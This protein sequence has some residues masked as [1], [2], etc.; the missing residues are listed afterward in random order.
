MSSWVVFRVMVAEWLGWILVAALMLECVDSQTSIKRLKDCGK[1]DRCKRREPKFMESPQNRITNEVPSAQCF[2]DDK[3]VEFGDCCLDIASHPNTQ[4]RKDMDCVSLSHNES[5]YAITDCQSENRKLVQLCKKEVQ[6]LDYH[7]TLDIPVYSPVTKTYFANVYCSLCDRSATIIEPVHIKIFCSDRTITT[8]EVLNKGKYNTGNLF[9]EIGEDRCFLIVEKNTT[10][11]RPCVDSKSTC[12]LKDGPL[13]EKCKAYSQIVTVGN[14]RFKN[15]HCAICNGHNTSSVDCWHGFDQRGFPSLTMLFDF[16]WNLDTCEFPK[17]VWDGLKRQCINLSI[18]YKSLLINKTSDQESPTD[19]T[20]IAEGYLTVICL[21]TSIFC[22]F[23]HISIS[24][25]LSNSNTLPAKILNSL[26]ISLIIAQIFF[27]CG[28]DPLIDVSESICKT[29]AILI[30][31]F[32]L[33]S[34][35]WMNVMSID[36]WRTFSNDPLKGQPRSHRKYAIYAWGS[37]GLLTAI[38][39]IFD[40][41]EWIPMK[42][43][44]LYAS[45]ENVCWFA[46]RLGLAIFFYLPISVLLFFNAIMFGTTVL[47]FQKHHKTS[48]LI[49]ASGRKEYNRLWLYIKLFVIMGLTWACGMIAALAKE[50]IF[51][52]PF[53][54]FNGL[55]GTFLFIMFD[56]KSGV[57]THVFKKMGIKQNEAPSTEQRKNRDDKTQTSKLSLSSETKLNNL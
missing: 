41:T 33:S 43:R 8:N 38:S 31:F 3:C 15:P 42:F 18:Q 45:A 39:L 52:Y 57:I 21:S 4:L 50:P 23:I 28:I 54:V 22:L 32:F 40:I 37:T 2:C 51:R 20:L 49:K 53:I 14:Q 24:F 47:G 26:S 56:L 36:L 30:H 27:L 12:S 55:Q 7:Y 5:V 17:T 46:N 16:N 1:R 10:H 35:F 19:L 29:V 44:P 11:G 13:A 6:E 34:F 9:W 25:F 48:A